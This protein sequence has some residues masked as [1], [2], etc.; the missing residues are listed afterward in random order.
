[1]YSELLTAKLKQTTK[2]DIL[3]NIQNVRADFKQRFNSLLT[4]NCRQHFD[5]LL[6]CETT[7]DIINWRLKSEDSYKLCINKNIEVEGTNSKKKIYINA[8][9]PKFK[10]KKY[11]LSSIY[12]FFS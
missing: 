3:A 4:V 12:Y 5:W 10:K 2:V 8:G 7:E 6:G 11:V 9:E 1:M